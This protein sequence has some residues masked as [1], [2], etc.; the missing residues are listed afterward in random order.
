[1][2]IL[3]YMVNKETHIDPTLLEGAT[4]QNLH[5]RVG[6]SSIG[7]PGLVSDPQRRP[8]CSIQLHRFPR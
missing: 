7:F 3:N 8:V 2:S 6:A 5:D 1:M 4:Q